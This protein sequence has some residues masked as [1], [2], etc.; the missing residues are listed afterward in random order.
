MLSEWAVAAQSRGAASDDSLRRKT[1]RPRGSA[2]SNVLLAEICQDRAAL[3]VKA[4]AVLSFYQ[5]TVAT[6]ATSKRTAKHL[7]PTAVFTRNTRR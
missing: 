3:L 2:K 7:P 5:A 6:R 4:I 1:R